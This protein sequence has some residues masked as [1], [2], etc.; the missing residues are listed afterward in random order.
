MTRKNTV[1][2]LNIIAVATI[3]VVAIGFSLQLGRVTGEPI[4]STTK[5]NE[6]Q[7]TERVPK[8]FPDH[9]TYEFLFRKVQ[10]LID[11]NIPDPRFCSMMLEEYEIN[12]TQAMKL[13]QIALSSLAEVKLQDLR[14]QEIISQVRA[15]HPNGR[16]APGQ[17]APVVPSELIAAQITR[18]GI[19]VH[20]QSRLRA[21]LGNDGFSR[22]DQKVK[23]KIQVPGLPTTTTQALASISTF[24]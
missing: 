5:I 18:N 3:V 6:A 14:A 2:T 8:Q 19:F 9:V 4:K 11:K 17:K 15:K 16:L 7:V 13:K 10:F 12:T 23:E 1:I 21:F 24:K 20:A 22:F